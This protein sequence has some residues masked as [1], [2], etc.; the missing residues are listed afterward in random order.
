MQ[1]N[2]K[3]I[4]NLLTLSGPLQLLFTLTIFS[5]PLPS[6]SE[7]IKIG[8]PLALTGDLADCGTEMKNT[9]TLVNETLGHGKY[10]LLF[11]DDRCNSTDAISIARKFI[12]EDK[13][14]YT[15]GFM[16]NQTLLSTAP[17]YDR[18][19]VYVFSGS[20]TSGDVHSLGRKNFRF[21]P[22]DLFGARR[23]FRFVNG[24]NKSLAI[25]SEQTD[26]TEMMERT[27]RKENEKS[28]NPIKLDTYQFLSSDKDL[29]TLL[30]KIKS[31]GA[32][33]LYVN[34]D[35]DTSYLNIIKQL[36]VI[37]FNKPLYTVYLA[38]SSIALSSAPALNNTVIFSNLPK[39]T[40]LASERGKS[41]LAEYAKRFGEPKCG[42]PVVP[43]TLGS[44]RLLDGLIS[45]KQ[46]P[47]SLLGGAK[48]D[49]GFLPPYSFDDGGNIQ[50]FE[51]EMQH[52]VDGKVELLEK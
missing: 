48:I 25:L 46:S 49:D 52:I 23:L 12:D 15:L 19:G 22:S 51:F 17:V 31:S 3:I 7:P 9:L 20:G 41:L 5:F 2:S 6:L 43:T 30:F 33:V 13:V 45:K 28:S 40:D 26:Y 18:A 37:N 8:V 24:R 47:E 21:F 50:G 36:S 32:E 44:F 4:L 1:S 38:G 10:E 27:F 29:R 35:S 11:Q 34:A 14:K 39:V 42:F 16:C